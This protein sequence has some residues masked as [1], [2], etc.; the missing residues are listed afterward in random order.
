MRK[1]VLKSIAEAVD[2]IENDMVLAIG[3][4]LTSNKPMALIRR[5][6]KKGVKGLTVISFPASMDIDLL[7]AA[8]CVKKLMVPFV[9]LERNTPIGPCFRKAVQEAKV[10]VW[11]AD[12]ALINA[13]LMAA[14]QNLPFLPW[15]GG[16]GTSI[17]DVNPDIK[18]FNDP[19]KG[20][21]LLAV[22]AVTP[23]VAIIHGIS[24]DIYGNI[25]QRS[26]CFSDALIARASKKTIV[27]V[28]KIVSND[29][30]RADP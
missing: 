7:V 27:E 30:I 20:E 24:G 13:A 23:D 22:P 17:P 12:S 14:S 3:G 1:S 4:L 25:Q 29:E 28:E 15:R 8:G 6:I 11:E 21:Q 18:L 5:L 10:D 26:G 9:S 16:I 2:L 19:I